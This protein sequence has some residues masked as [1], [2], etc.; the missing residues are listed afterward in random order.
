MSGKGRTIAVCGKGGVGKTVFTAIM[1]KLLSSRGDMKI[2]VIDAD[3]ASGLVP[4]LGVK[5]EKTINDIRLKIIKSIKESK[6]GDKLEISS[7]L[8]YEILDALAEYPGLAVLSIGRPEDEG[9]YCRVNDLLKDAI[10]LLS[11]SFD[12]TLIDGEA[13]I[14]QINRRVMMDVDDL[15]IVSD[16]SVKGVNTM[17]TILHVAKEGNAVNYS[18]IGAVVNKARSE[19]EAKQAMD[20]VSIDFLGWIPEDETVREYDFSGKSL[21]E[22]P[23]DNQSVEAVKKILENMRV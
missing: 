16:T 7:M 22:L 23:D 8:D 3:P 11:K 9:C 14:E 19:K 12:L 1:T 13:G 18:R 10:K 2:L 4:T 5:V 15:V 6:G 17:S 20:G 21:L